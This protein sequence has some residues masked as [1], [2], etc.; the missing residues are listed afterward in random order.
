MASSLNQA[1]GSVDQSIIGADLQLHREVQSALIET[2]L[3]EKK[4]KTVKDYHRRI[5]K[6]ISWLETEE[7][8]YY[9]LG[10]VRTTEHDRLD[11]QRY[12]FGLP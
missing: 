11:P 10:V 9:L 4:S 5:N 2:E 7:P 12:L 6:I 1:G 8:E 3:F